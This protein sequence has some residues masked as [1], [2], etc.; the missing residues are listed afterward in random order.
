MDLFNNEP[1]GDFDVK[2]P[3]RSSVQVTGDGA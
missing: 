3:L 1:Q 2:G